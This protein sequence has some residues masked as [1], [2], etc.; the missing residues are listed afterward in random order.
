MGGNTQ[1]LEAHSRS[2]TKKQVEMHI[3]KINEHIENKDCKRLI[4]RMILLK[5]DM[6]ID[7]KKGIDDKVNGVLN[8]VDQ[9]IKDMLKNC[10][11]VKLSKSEISAYKSRIRKIVNGS[12]CG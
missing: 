11:D 4:N 6:D 1:K 12:N 3:N 8:H 5:L 7:K 10:P 9:I 2:L